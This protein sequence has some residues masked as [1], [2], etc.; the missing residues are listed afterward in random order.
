MRNILLSVLLLGLVG[1]AER[2]QVTPGE[3]SY[4]GKHDTK[5]WD[6]EPFKGDR[7]G[8]ENHIKARQLTQ[9]EDR[10]LYQ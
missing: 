9:H 2:D 8:W 6:N 5:P 4:Q 1:C 10:R 7:A 3:R